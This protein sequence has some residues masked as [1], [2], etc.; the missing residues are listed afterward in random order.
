[1]NFIKI[2][3]LHYKVAVHIMRLFPVISFLCGFQEFQLP[4][5]HMRVVVGKDYHDFRLLTESDKTLK[6]EGLYK[7]AKVCSIIQIIYSFLHY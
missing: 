7:S 6:S 4:A 5:K 2:V 1:M 3:F